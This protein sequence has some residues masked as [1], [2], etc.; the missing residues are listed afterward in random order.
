MSTQARAR[1]IE[2]VQE[3]IHKNGQGRAIYI[4]FFQRLNLAE[5][6]L[7]GGLSNLFNLA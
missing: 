5:N 7:T 6:G 1:K 3:R 2:C 4:I